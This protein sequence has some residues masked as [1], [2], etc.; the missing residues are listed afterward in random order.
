MQGKASSLFSP[1][2]K[3][4]AEHTVGQITWHLHCALKIVTRPHMHASYV[5]MWLA[6]GGMTMCTSWTRDAAAGIFR[7]TGDGAGAVELPLGS[8]ACTDNCCCS[9]FS[10][11]KTFFSMRA[12]R[13]RVESS[14]LQGNS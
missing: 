13:L 4:A 6:C 7:S 10:D 8:A 14:Y 3:N 9:C 11:I 1:L 5:F 12:L 2:H